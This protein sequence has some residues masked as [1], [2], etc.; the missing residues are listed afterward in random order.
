M[1]LLARQN[2]TAAPIDIDPHAYSLED[3]VLRED[4]PYVDVSPLECPLSLEKEYL[5]KT[6]VKP[7]QLEKEMSSGL[8][9]RYRDALRL[10][11]AIENDEISILS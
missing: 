11:Y 3:F 5:F 1:I 6:M 2:I 9:D 4:Q 10:Y 8:V 7:L